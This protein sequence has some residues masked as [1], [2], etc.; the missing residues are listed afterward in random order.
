MP[1]ASVTTPSLQALQCYSQGMQVLYGK[2]DY[3]EA[4]SWL[5][6]AVEL[7]PNFAMAY[8][9]VGD[10]Y[11]I[12]GE[13]DSA[14]QYTRKAFELRDHVSERERAL[15]E[16]HYYY[17]VLGDIKN[18]RRSCE[19]LAKLYPYSE[20]AHTSI[21]TF[22]ETV[23][24]YDL[25]IAE[26]REALRLA[27][28]RSFLYR[29]V[30]YSYLVSDRLQDA[31]SIIDRAHAMHLD[32]NLTSVRYSMAF[33]REDSSAMAREVA[34]V[35]GKPEVEDLLLALHADTGAYAGHLQTARTLSQ[36]AAASAEQA[37]RR[38]TSALYYAA[39][40]VREGRC[41]ATQTQPNNKR[42]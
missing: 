39:S 34:S 10:V 11:A 35:A 22:A 7:D 12:L 3:P 24:Q 18:A 15:I 19:L 27:P 13:T 5:R 1:L 30:A 21:A 17:Y 6:K 38:E 20:D 29:D 40:A 41:S 25:G 16:A 28:G 32:E 36:R 31:S 23:G 9:A 26:F 2:F 37:G 4:L 8:W 42:R 14:I 33:Y